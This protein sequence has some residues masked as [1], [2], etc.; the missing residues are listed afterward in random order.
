MITQNHFHSKTP[1]HLHADDSNQ[2]DD[3]IIESGIC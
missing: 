2:L 3:V 1:G